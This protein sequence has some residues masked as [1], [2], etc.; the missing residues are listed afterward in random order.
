MP[1]QITPLS[2][3]LGAVVQGVQLSQPLSLI[4]KQQLEQALLQHQ[5][6][7]FR[8]QPITPAQQ[9]HLAE[10]FGMLHVHPIF[11]KVAEQPEI[12]VLDTE[13][14]DLTD[15]ALWHTDVTFLAKPAMGAILSAKI[16][17]AVGGDTLWASS[18]AAY[19]GLSAP[20]QRLLEGLSATH[21]I[22]LSFPEARFAIDSQQKRHYQ[23]VTQNN[24]PVS[25]P[26]IR[27]HPQTGEKGL[28]VSQGFTRCINELSTA[29]SDALLAFLFAHSTQPAYSIR[30]QW[31]VNDIAF[32]DNR[33]TQHYAVLDYLP[34]RR[35]MHRATILGDRP[36]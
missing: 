19:Q 2:P 36:Y 35:V 33:I 30:W 7:F 8:D 9:K 24:P 15:N 21:D 6:L 29:E 25:H 27:I 10:Q 31:R 28:F 4:T 5:V 18:S 20:M 3:A 22:S 32:W 23:Q 17:P 14:T 26:V 13:L 11:P 34:H 16:L 12:I 1:L